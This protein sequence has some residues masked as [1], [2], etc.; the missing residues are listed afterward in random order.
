[1]DS[2]REA[3]KVLVSEMAGTLLTIAKDVK[4]QIEFNPTKVKAYRLLGYENRLLA[5]EDFADDTKDAGE[6]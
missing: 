1:I 6:L 2:I 4:I 3:N 5:K